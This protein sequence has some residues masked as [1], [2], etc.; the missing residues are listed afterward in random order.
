MWVGGCVSRVF[1]ILEK[2]DIPQRKLSGE[3]IFFKWGGGGGR[4][5]DEASRKGGK[6]WTSV[7]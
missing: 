3:V 2:K 6:T 4:T 7:I 1:R 5:R